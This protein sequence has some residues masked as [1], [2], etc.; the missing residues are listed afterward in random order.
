[1]PHTFREGRA[2]AERIRQVRRLA[3][4]QDK[5]LAELG[6]GTASWSVLQALERQDGVGTASGLA[7]RLSVSRQAVQR[8]LNRLAEAGLIDLV[9]DPGD[10]R[11]RLAR[12]T[13]LGRSRVER[14]RHLIERRGV[15]ADS[16]KRDGSA[17]AVSA[18]LS[19]VPPRGSERVRDYLLGEIR[20]GHLQ[21]GDKLP[22]ERELASELD[23]GRPVIREALRSLE[24][25]GVLKIARGARGGAFVRESGADG[26]RQSIDAMLVLGR[27]PLSNLLDMRS[28]LLAEGARLG[29]VHGSEADYAAIEANIAELA[30]VL[31]D[32]DQVRGIGPAIEFY[33][34]VARASHNRLLSLIMDALA[35]LIAEMLTEMKHWPRTDAITPRREVLAAMRV[36][37]TELSERIIREHSQES[38]SVLAAYGELLVEKIGPLGSFG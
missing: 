36:G 15:A 24:I 31:D 12:I 14:A 13:S 23:V 30:G 1:M 4:A 32:E 28:I 19:V 26:I 2:V 37:N 33:K 7:R 29:A 10:A 27:L 22:S 38:N 6:L 25:S 9:S 21:S 18:E 16:E 34:L 3:H 35:D 20:S 17:G 8:Q 11:S 5:L